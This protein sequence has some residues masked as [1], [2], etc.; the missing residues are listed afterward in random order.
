MNINFR[1]HIMVQLSVISLVLPLSLAQ[2]EE[3]KTSWG[4]GAGVGL[5]DKGYAGFDSE[6]KVLPI[7]YFDNKWIHVAGTDLDIKVGQLGNVA[8]SAH[9]KF[10]VGDV[11]EE[12]DSYIFEGME[13]RQSSIWLGSK[14]EWKNS[15]VDTSLEILTD[16]TDKSDGQQASLDLSR[17]FQITDHLSFEPSININWYSEKYV[18]YYYGVQAVEAID[19]RDEF[20]GEASV[21]YGASARFRYAF[22]KHQSVSLGFKYESF[23]QEIK[24]SPLVDKNYSSTVSAFYLY[25]F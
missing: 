5:I 2:A 8:F 25:R 3:N 22:D 9:A 6:T 1:Y 10:G 20:H 23:G 14:V 15:V 11:Y 17:T 16:A 13:N 18:D 21:N 12:S 19:G 7:F 24:D 4:L